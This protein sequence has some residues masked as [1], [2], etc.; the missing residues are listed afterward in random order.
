MAEP[1]RIPF[2][3]HELPGYLVCGGERPAPTLIAHGGFDSTAEELYHWIG[4]HA[5]TR[6]WNCLTFEGPGQWG[7]VFDQPPLLM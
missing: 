6:G 4:V 5:A 1:L 7:P 2:G 3:G